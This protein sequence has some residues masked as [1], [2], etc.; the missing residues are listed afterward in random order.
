MRLKPSDQILNALLSKAKIALQLSTREGFEV[1]VSEAIH[2]GKPVIASRAGGIPLQVEH[3][4]NG[5]L[6][7]V[8]D[9]EAVAKYLFDLWTDQ[10]LYNRM[11]KAAWETVSDEV[12]TVGNAL[13]W[14]YL[15][16]QLTAG[17]SVKPNGRWIND[18]A[19]EEA[20]IP[21]EK[22][23]NRLKRA[24]RVENMG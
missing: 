11:S 20:G 21:Y 15:A 17:K 22:G 24:V 14:L 5:F 8:G 4:K 3:E 7:E 9:Q 19:R 23:E 13:C 18:M 16:S 12:T 2:K 1:K 6:V 10:D